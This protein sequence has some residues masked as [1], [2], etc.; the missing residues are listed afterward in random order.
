[1]ED[2][3]GLGV[4]Q[5][6]KV[7]ETATSHRTSRKPA[8]CRAAAC[9]SPC[10]GHRSPGENH[11]EWKSAR[12]K[13]AFD[14]FPVAADGGPLGDHLAIIGRVGLGFRTDRGREAAEQ[15]WRW[16]VRLHRVSR[17]P[18]GS[19]CPR[20]GLPAD[21]CGGAKTR[22]AVFAV[23]Q[24]TTAADHAALATVSSLETADPSGRISK[25]G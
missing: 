19:T 2:V 13:N 1:M 20:F 14:F 23:F 21:S 15:R 16:C 7:P 9:L 8:G 4:G 10:N 12:K 24:P 5:S 6:P 11:P 18:R 17:I 25:C 22:V 3:A